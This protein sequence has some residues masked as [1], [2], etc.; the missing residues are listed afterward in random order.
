MERISSEASVALDLRKAAPV[1]ELVEELTGISIT[2]VK[3]EQYRWLAKG[4]GTFRSYTLCVHFPERDQLMVVEPQVVVRHC[5]HQT[6]L[7]PWTVLAGGR[8]CGTLSRLADA[9]AIGLAI[10][11]RKLD[12]VT[13]GDH[14]EYVEVVDEVRM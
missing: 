9:Q 8:F 1:R 4:K 7:Y 10:G 14:D 6:A 12:V 2:E 3:S 5:G 11:A 13:V